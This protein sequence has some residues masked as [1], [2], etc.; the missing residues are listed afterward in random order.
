MDQAT[1]INK[2]VSIV[3]YY[4][5]N[6]ARRLRCFPK[7]MEYDGRRINFTET[8]NIQP[9]EYT[10][11]EVHIFDMSDGEADYRLEFNPAT[12]NWKLIAIIA[13]RYEPAFSQFAATV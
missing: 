3:A 6:S 12:L 1:L 11:G 10:E 13:R 4:F 9:V 5:K 7:R 2:D 8:G